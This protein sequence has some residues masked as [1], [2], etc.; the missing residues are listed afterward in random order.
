M[1]K[2]SAMERNYHIFYML[3]SGASDEEKESWSMGDLK[4]HHFTS[5]SGCFDRRDGV[6]DADLFTELIDAFRVMGFHEFEKVRCFVTWQCIVYPNLV[7]GDAFS[8]ST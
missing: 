8:P 1:V 4:S 7:M 3:A 2:H 5:Q 6:L